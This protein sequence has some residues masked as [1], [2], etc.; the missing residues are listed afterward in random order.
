MVKISTI[1]NWL[2]Y[3]IALL[4]FIPLFPYLEPLP[5]LVF[6]IALTAG[7]LIDRNNWPLNSRVTTGISIL[8]FVFYATQFSRANLVGPAVN[9]LVLLLAVRLF[10]EKN[11]RNYLQVYTLAL[12][13]LAGSSLFSLSA[14]FLCYFLLMLTFIAVSLVFLTYHS[15]SAS[16]F[17]S[18]AGLKKILSVAILMPAASFPLILL[19]FFILPRTQYPLWHD[20]QVRGT[21]VTGFSE[22]VELGTSSTVGDVRSV[23]FRVKCDKLASNLLYWRGIVLN[24]IEG[25]SWIRSN[26]PVAEDAF[27]GKGESIRQTIF[28]EPGRP[29]YLLALNLPRSIS[30]IRV[31]TSPDSTFMR[32]GA[33]SGH[34]KYEAL[35]VLS[36]TLITKGGIDTDFY[37]KIPRL[38]SQRMLQLGKSVAEKRRD[39]VGKIALLEEFYR[40]D[41]LTYSRT[42]LPMGDNPLDEFLFEKKRGHCE[43]FASSFALL[44]RV[45]GVPSRIVG[46]YLGGDYNELGGYYVITEDM[47]HVWVEAYVAGKGWLTVDP[48]G[49]A[50]NSAKLERSGQSGLIRKIVLLF[51]ALSYYWNLTVINYDLEGQLSLISRANFEL[52]RQTF[53]ANL[54]HRVLYLLIPVL[55]LAGMIT[56]K[57]RAGVSREER[58]LRD[59]ISLLHRLYGMK[60][61]PTR[62]LHELSTS[63]HDP[64]VDRFVAIYGA[65]IYHDRRLFPE[66]IRELH[67]VT[68]NLCKR[69][70]KRLSGRDKGTS[71]HPST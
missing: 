21:R 71:G 40:N 30:G 54:T 14:L 49:W 44:L 39:S 1:L 27:V 51:D 12:F 23:A 24:T 52:K 55:I 56:L 32:K 35:S 5:R 38:M 18:L 3:G 13:S 60:I 58:I 59:F 37:L 62:G 68:D 16:Q 47:A 6:P 42:G 8:F 64:D 66:E 19:F 33:P 11:A 4:G 67:D 7:F 25:K 15:A 48:S 10:S 69:H 17:V 61:D 65:A 46:G 26:P 20:L 2:A 43:F 41:K 70:K 45:A 57:R 34:E 63:L 36:D 50:V 29:A 53:P 9:L 31:T 28:P 22:K